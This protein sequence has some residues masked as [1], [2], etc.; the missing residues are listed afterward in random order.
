MAMGIRRSPWRWLYRTLLALFVLV[1]LGVLAVLARWMMLTGPEGGWTAMMRLFQNGP[2]TIE[3]F[4]I[5]PARTLH[6]GSSAAALP[7]AAD[8]V[9]L[10][11]IEM[12]PGQQRDL[13]A[14]AADTDTLAL[15]VVAGPAMVL[16][17]YQH[18]H[19]PATL[20]QLFSVSK[21]ITSILVGMA[22]ADRHLRST[23]QPVTE[24]VPEL[25]G[26]GFEQVRLG[27]LLAMR[28]NL[29]YTENDNPFGRH[30][31]LNYTS[32][33][34]RMILGFRLA[35]GPGGEFRYK[36]G[37]TALL[38]LVL[39]RALAPETIAAYA[40]RRL[41]M[42]L[43]MEQPGVWSLD[44]EEG[45]E[46]TWCCL[47]TSTRDLARIGMLVRDRGLWQ[48]ERLL[49][50]AWIEASLQP[51]F[52]AAQWD[53]ELAAAGLANYG[54]AWWLGAPEHG[55]ALALGKDGQ[56]LYVAPS[57]GI[58]VVRLGRSQGALGSGRWL[59]VFRQLAAH[60]RSSA[61]EP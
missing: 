49:P 40:Q 16:E 42:P 57:A 6:T 60:Y 17:H 18:G 15:I 34:E 22:I 5:Y 59:T 56:Y 44:R 31:A 30:I 45:L 35:A 51:Q 36:S 19:G 24:L 55:D 47:A 2:T 20:S 12:P 3:D 11:T 58:V 50:A 7:T 27:D 29:D 61:V 41:W 26:H 53:Q 9:P 43:A 25:A 38:S 8:I 46:K 4:R 54:L 52:G 10:P 14:F 1:V 23:D 21:S 33:L 32:Q 13:A 39:A 37:D 48:G 28:S